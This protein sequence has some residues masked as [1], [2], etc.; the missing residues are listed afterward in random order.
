MLVRVRIF[1]SCWS[2]QTVGTEVS[3][4]LT[5]LPRMS[6]RLDAVRTLSLVANM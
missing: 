1:V 4:E 3:G 5:R 2:A 6:N